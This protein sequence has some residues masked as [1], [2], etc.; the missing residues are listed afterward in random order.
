MLN[1]K[2]YTAVIVFVDLFDLGGK[3]GSQLCH[4]EFVAATLLMASG[5]TAPPYSSEMP[6]NYFSTSRQRSEGRK[7]LN[8]MRH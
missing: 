5:R 6:T 7:Y 4:L 8:G 3:I 2:T 1:Y